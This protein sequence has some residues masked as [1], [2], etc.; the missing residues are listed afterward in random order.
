MYQQAGWLLPT[1]T[2][3]LLMVICGAGG[4]M[5]VECMAMMPHNGSFRRRIEYT[6]VMRHYCSRRAYQLI[7]LFFQ[8]SLTITNLSLIVQSIQVM[9]FTI[10]AIAGKSCTVPQFSPSFTFACPAKVDNNI[11]PFATDVWCVPLGLYFTALFVIPLGLVNLDDNIKVQKAAFYSLITI[12]LIWVGVLASNQPSSSNVPVMGSTLNT[13]LGTSLF[14]FAFVSSVPSWVNEKREDVSIVKTL[15][16]VLPLAVV[17]F[18]VMGW[19]GGA[20]FPDWTTDETLLDKLQGT[21][22]LGQITFYA[23]PIIVNLTS[24]PVLS[25]FQRYNLLKERVCGRAMANFLAVV[26]PWL[27]AIPLYNGSGYQNLANWG[28]VLVTSVVNFIVPTVVYII[29]VRRR[30]REMEELRLRRER[31]ELLTP[32]PAP[33]AEPAD[34]AVVVVTTDAGQQQEEVGE[35]AGRCRTE[36]RE[37]LAVG[38]GSGGMAARRERR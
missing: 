15:C 6:S 3:L 18:V 23:F 36:E 34:G 25:I 17:I 12:V 38:L 30:D 29:A 1:L 11:T 7:H 8:L 19:L 20:A 24:I 14:N 21:G 28:G 35:T 9:D 13:V 4:L 22:I 32:V 31:G 16:A 26:L 33:T 10:A 37:L 5:L 27:I 2:L